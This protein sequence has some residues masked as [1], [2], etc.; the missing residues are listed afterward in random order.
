MHRIP[1]ADTI[2]E[3]NGKIL[4]HR[5]R[6]PPGKGKLDL[7]GGYVDPEEELEAAAVR[8]IRE[9]TGFSVKIIAKLGSFDYFDR[10]DKQM[11]VF[12]GKITGGSLQHSVE[13]DP[14]WVPMNE[15]TAS[16]LAFPQVHVN[17]LNAYFEKQGL[18]QRVR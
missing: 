5:R 8:E 10:Q 17:V 4:M 6:F 9:E 12:I 15:I 14:L 13:S 1:I 3:E 16:D 7:P 11:H 2:V 18:S